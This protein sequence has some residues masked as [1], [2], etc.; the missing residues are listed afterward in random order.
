MVKPDATQHLGGIL[1]AIYEAGITVVNLRKAWLS[2]AE[3][4]LFYEVHRERPF[5]PKLQGKHLADLSTISVRPVCAADGYI[6]HH[7]STQ[8]ALHRTGVSNLDRHM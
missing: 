6:G 5:F 4:A 1:T 7:S 2:P 8:S 3:A